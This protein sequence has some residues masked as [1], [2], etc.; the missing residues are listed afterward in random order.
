MACFPRQGCAQGTLAPLFLSTNGDGSITPLQNGQLLEVGQNY[1]MTALAGSGFAFSSWQPVHVFISISSVTNAGT[2]YSTTNIVFSPLPEYADAPSLT[3]TM[4][5]PI[6]VAG[7]NPNVTE[8][9][10][11]QANFVPVPEPSDAS[12]IACGFA[13][14]MFLRRKQTT[15]NTGVTTY[16]K[17]RRH[18]GSCFGNIFPWRSPEFATM[19]ILL[20]V[21]GGNMLHANPT[22]GTVTQGAATISGAGS[23]QVT[24]NQTSPNACINWQTF[25]LAAGETTIFNQPSSSSVTWNYIND[26]NASSINGNINAIGYVILQ[27]PNGFSVGGQAS[28]TAHG[29]VMTTAS[30]PALNLSSGGPWSFNT[31]PPTANIVNY[32]QINITGG[33]SAFL[34]ANNIQNHG[35]ISA[36]GGNIGLY[37]GQS[38]L[39]STAPD[40]RGLSAQVTLPQGSVDNEGRLIADGGSIVARAQLVNQNGL[41]QANTAQNVNGTIELVAGDPRNASDSGN[42]NAALN[43]GPGSTISATGDSTAASPSSGGSVTIQSGNNFSDQAGSAINIAGGT[44]GGNGGQVEISAPQMGVLNSIIRG[45]AADGFSGG[46]LTLDPA[47]IWL[48]SADTDPAAPSGYSVV[49]VNSFS[50]LSQINLQ[51]DN[52][53]TLNTLWA[54]A[55]QT[56]AAGLSLSAGNN[57]TLDDGSGIQAGQNWSVNLTAGTAYSGTVRPGSG[58]DGIYLNGSA[59][60]QTANGDLNLD[61]ANEVIVNRGAIRTTGGGN[62]AVMAEYGNVNSGINAIGYDYLTTAPYY[63]PDLNLGGISTEAGGNVTIHAGGDVISFPTTTVAAGDPGAGAFDPAAPGNVTITAGGSVYGHFV[64]ADGTGTINAGQNIG[65]ALQNVALSLVNGGWNLNAPNGN[66]YLQEVRNPNGVFDN[67]TTLNRQT[68]RSTPTPGNHLFDYDPQAWVDLTAGSAVYLTGFD[69]PRP[70]DPVPLLLPPTVIINAGPGGV[71]LDTPNA[72]D[73]QNNSVALSADYGIILFPSPY[74]SLQI[75]TTGGGWLSSGNAG[76]SDTT[77]M[78]SDSGLTQWYNNAVSGGLLPF[79][80]QDHASVPVLLNNSD[81]VMINLTGSQMVNGIPILAGMESI[82]LQ[83]DKATR[84]NIAGDMIGCSFY[85]ENLQ[86]AGPASVT[87][88]NVGGQIYNAG[89]FTS[90]VLDQGL[91]ALPAADIPA[92]SGLPAGVSLSSWYLALA[93]AVDPT[94]KVFTQSYSDPSQLAG[95]I[96]GAVA[97]PGLNFSSLIYNPNTKTLTAIG[98]MSSDLLAALQSPTLT[99]VR[100]GPNGYPLLD[101]SGHFVLDT[102]Y[103]DYTSQPVP[104]GANTWLPLA[105][106]SQISSLYADSQA[107]VPLNGAAGAYVIGGPG[108]FDVTA[109]SISLGNSRGILSVGNGQAPPGRDYSYLTPYMT[110]GAD[111]NITAGNLEMPASTI[112]SLGGGSVTVTCTGE[113]PNSPLNAS[114]AGVSMDLG[115]QDLLNFEAQIMNENQLGLG[116][117]STAGGNVDV[118]AE[119]TINVDSSRIATFDGGDVTVES[120]MGDV[121]A[122]TGGTSV[123]PVNYY[124]PGYS[125]GNPVEIVP[126]NGI[127][128]GTLTAARHLPPGAVRLPGNVTVKADQGSIYAN[129]GGISQVAYDEI[130]SAASGSATITLIADG[131]PDLGQGNIVL[132]SSGVIGVNVVAKAAGTITGLII[133]Q[134]NADISAAQSFAGTVL[135]GGKTTLASGGTISGIIVAGG[136]VNTSG[137]GNLTASVFSSSV[138]GGA[139]TLATSSTVSSAGQSAAGQTS[140]ENQQQVASNNNDND[141]E[142]KKK[143]A[144]LTRSVGRVTVILPKAG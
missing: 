39:V 62:I 119:G 13:A 7:G 142:K 115:S 40:G 17:I 106:F 41:V 132:G 96:N 129:A 124:A 51:A 2:T 36:P 1:D 114:G 81:P 20:L 26:P 95:V 49:N 9:F 144:N 35:T 123:I 108:Q 23:S 89:S 94:S 92:A 93:L 48:A 137:G 63:L 52:N 103:N 122:G 141:D 50:G 38:V 127:M 112:A 117:Y 56:A 69:L 120:L 65:T 139:G 72:V 68:R 111:I 12:F 86:A 47:N 97:F 67:L 59:Y 138:N 77:L 22:G 99:L 143:K 15:K 8:N 136:G 29:L 116:I 130:L 134:Q 14:V 42:A 85:G 6:V 75:T 4:Q 90:V 140:A 87:S 19:G 74:Q 135:S 131:S 25:N 88:I 83:M 79:G 102:I 53:I 125:G 118:T 98:P 100:Y 28:I 27:N 37:A 31:P 16:F 71:V 18:L 105:D 46:I 82:I 58:S 30:T 128:A 43:L 110:S 107:S 11:W 91:P 60:L 24:I 54:L 44:Q 57:I 109:G 121:N 80:P 133:S 55:D 34:I 70:N 78:M 21:L 104:P 66:I 33:G 113:I 84:I 32:G 126:A 73:A 76:G 61:A 10:G 64:E 45:G 3:F 5:S 101:A